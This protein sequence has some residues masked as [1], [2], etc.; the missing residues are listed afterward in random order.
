MRDTHEWCRH[1]HEHDPL[2]CMYV[3][4]RCLV[5]FLCV[6]GGTSQPPHHMPLQSNQKKTPTPL[7]LVCPPVRLSVCECLSSVSVSLEVEVQLED[8]PVEHAPKAL[9]VLQLPLPVQNLEGHVL[10]GRPGVEAD[11]ARLGRVGGLQGVRGRLGGVEQVGVEEVKLVALY[12]LGRRVVVVVVRLVVLVPLVAC[13]DAVEKTR[14]TRPVFVFPVVLLLSECVLGLGLHDLLVAGHGL[15]LLAHKVVKRK[16]LDAQVGGVAPALVRLPPGLHCCGGQADGPPGL[17]LLD[18]GLTQLH[19]LL[20]LLRRLQNLHTKPLDFIHR[21]DTR[22]VWPGTDLPLLCNHIL[23]TGRCSSSSSG[24]GFRGWCGE[25][26]GCVVLVV[27]LELGGV[28]PVVVGVD[29]RADKVLRPAGVLLL[30]GR[31]VVT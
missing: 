9:L 29:A 24:R 22:A 30:L 15:P 6:S 5:S 8:A 2:T 4:T 20:V 26:W 31:L 7:P 10:V 21:P 25:G 17:L 28:S 11:D 19:A 23:N 12:H 18:E 1:T 27:W 13:L 16:L 3:H 14:L